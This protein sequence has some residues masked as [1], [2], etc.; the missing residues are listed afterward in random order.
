MVNEVIAKEA[1]AAADHIENV[2]AYVQ[3][4]IKDAA[5]CKPGECDNCDFLMLLNKDLERIRPEHTNVIRALANKLEGLELGDDD[6]MLL[7]G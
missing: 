4:R 3:R 6:A 1:I 5:S 2:I 7:S